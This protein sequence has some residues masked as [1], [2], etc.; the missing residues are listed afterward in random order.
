MEYVLDLDLHA[1]FRLAAD[2]SVFV[3]TEIS[4]ASAMRVSLMINF[5]FFPSTTIITRLSSANILWPLWY[6]TTSASSASTSISNSHLLCSKYGHCGPSIS[7]CNICQS[8]LKYWG[9]DKSD[10]RRKS[11]GDRPAPGELPEMH[12][13]K[14]RIAVYDALHRNKVEEKNPLFKK[15]FPKL[16]QIC[17][18]YVLWIIYMNEILVCK[19]WRICRMYTN[20]TMYF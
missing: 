13:K 15:C 18:M 8:L 3:L 20:C 6:Q 9:P 2:L 7:V 1:T 4:P 14:L 10:A 17:K 16:F 5:R 12:K 11:S 19:L